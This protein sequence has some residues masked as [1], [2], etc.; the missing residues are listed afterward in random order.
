MAVPLLLIVSL[1]IVSLA[2][3]CAPSKEANPKVVE[4]W[5]MPNSLEPITDL[6]NLLKPFEKETGIKVILTS[7]DWGAAWN[8]IT[9]A[10]TSGD[11]PDLV[12]LGSTWVSAITGMGALEELSKEAVA[13][14][15]GAKTF[16][17]VAWQTT[18]IEG[19]GKT[20]AIPWFVDAR[21]LFYRTDAFKKAKVDTGELAS[22]DS[23]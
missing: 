8:K 15:G 17:P 10:A 4:M 12:Q 5:V 19:S 13:A 16:V 11:V 6:E 1:L 7:V 21:G 3:G 14:L 23:F 9:P 18:V 2:I 22:W 20:T